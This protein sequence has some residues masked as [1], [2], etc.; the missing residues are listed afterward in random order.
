MT[1]QIMDKQDVYLESIREAYPNLVIH[2]ARLHTTEGQFNDIVFVNDDLIFR[3]PRY[4]DSIQDF[5]QEIEILKKLQGHVSLPIPDPIYANS[6]TKS[7]GNVFMGYQLLPGKPLFREV[8]G[9]ITYEPLLESLARQLADFLHGLHSL[10]PASLRL[11]LPIRDGLAESKTFY[12]DIQEHLF[13]LMRPDAR[14][15]IT[16]HFEEYFDNPALYEYQPAII[17]GDFGG[18]NIL[19]DRD[20]ITGIIDFGFAGLDDPARDIAAVSTYGD[21]FFARICGYYPGIASLL[22]RATFYRGTFA[23]YE[24]LHGFRNNDLQAFANGME[25]YV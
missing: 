8:L 17:H 23:L 18:S 15:S 16:S 1:K 2:A 25:Q 7:V 3:F 14:D 6:G 22:E 13:R 21:A 5:L 4:E 12:F 9:E 24:A 11:D 19:F 10:G 20:K